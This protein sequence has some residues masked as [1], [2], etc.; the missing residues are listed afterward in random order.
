MVRE[1]HIRGLYDKEIIWYRNYMIKKLNNE[2]KLY[3]K[4]RI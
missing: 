4:R 3:N 1:T 2:K